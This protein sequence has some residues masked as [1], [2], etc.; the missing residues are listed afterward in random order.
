MRTDQKACQAFWS[1]SQPRDS[2][3]EPRALNSGSSELCNMLADWLK[4]SEAA[5]QKACLTWPVRVCL[6]RDFRF[7]GKKDKDMNHDGGH[8]TCLH[9]AQIIRSSAR[10]TVRLGPLPGRVHGPTRPAPRAQSIRV[11]GMVGLLPEPFLK[12]LHQARGLLSIF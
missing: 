7:V 6:A 9:N 5:N 3:L 8:G 4:E 11:P 1:V 10:S 12:P 2:S